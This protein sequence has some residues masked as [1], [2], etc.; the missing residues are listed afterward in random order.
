VK[1]PPW[2]FR[3]LTPTAPGGVAVIRIEGD[4][5]EFFH[6]SGVAIVPPERRGI[7]LLADLDR[8]LV[9]RW[10][11]TVL[12]L[13]PHGGV[14][15]VRAVADWLIALGGP[16]SA[17]SEAGRWPEANDAV[18][19]HMLD[20]LARAASPGAVPL[21]LR[22]PAL[23]RGGGV[24]SPLRD[25]VLNQ[26]IEPPLIAAI[27]PPNVGKSSLLNALAG[28][29]VAIAADEPGTTRDH[30]GVLL[31]LGG[32]VVRYCD[33][34]GIRADTSRDEREAIDRAMAVA[35]AANLVLNCGDHTADPIATTALSKLLGAPGQATLTIATRSDLGRQTFLADHSAS[36][37]ETESITALAQLLRE[38]LVPASLE[39]SE[40][41]WRFWTEP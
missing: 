31:D 21:L 15:V 26:L 9:C 39:Q 34:P 16:Q 24:S 3:V 23:W 38:T 5:N 12:D 28:R 18:D 40:T 30:V 14:L 33:T 25:A 2:A 13:M 22:Q 37:R 36:V 20:A 29:T 4:L 19:A 35:R 6:G 41:P 27:G 8:G 32:L 17:L 11:A 7:R 1:R 10:N